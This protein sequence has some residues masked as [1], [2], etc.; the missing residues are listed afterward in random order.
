MK[1]IVLG[2]AG[3]MGHVAVEGLV[4]SGVAS[5]ILIADK[6]MERAETLAQ[7]LSRPGVTVAARSIDVND[8]RAL[9]RL[10][11]EGDLALGAIGPFY[12]FEEHVVRA[13]I[14][15]GV[16]YLSICDDY[17]ATQVVLGLDGF[18]RERG[19][20]IVTGLGMSPGITNML[21]SYGYEKMERVK[22]INVSWSA[23]AYGSVSEAVMRHTF[24]CFRGQV[25]TFLNG[26]ETWVQ[27]GKGTEKKTFPRP[28]RI[29][30]VWY[31]GH[32]EPVTLSKYLTGV[33]EV[34]IK[35]G[36]T[37]AWMAH[38]IM[39][40]ARVHLFESSQGMEIW[41]RVPN[42]LTL[43]RRKKQAEE[44]VLG[45]RVDIIGEK[46]GEEIHSAYGCAE[47]M[48]KATGLSLAIGAQM[49][50]R[51]DVRVQPGVMAPEVVFDPKIFL[52]EL[53]KRDILIYEG[54]QM[55]EAMTL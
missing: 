10:L 2:G 55:R 19:V 42:P 45:M 50:L 39:L 7:N 12:A 53:R 22:R 32:P 36:I 48:A 34:T 8:S 15:S 35:G 16:D 3:R 1:T 54:D 49:F 26:E 18:A 4:E 13:A 29:S 40:S 24:H 11:Q 23:P 30:K 14:E 21:A 5:E 51:D 41:M 27:A 37:P 43:L 9:S 20:R 6:T 31:V 33:E 44:I 38:L 46:G 17:E 28:I 25:P 47:N 52:K